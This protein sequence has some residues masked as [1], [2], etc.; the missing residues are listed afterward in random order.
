MVAKIATIHNNG[1][2]NCY[3]LLQLALSVDLLHQNIIKL[4]FLPSAK[5]V[6]KET[7]EGLGQSIQL[8]CSRFNFQFQFITMSLHKRH[9][10]ALGFT[11]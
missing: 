11:I 8:I 5:S 9:E 4:R 6:S 2:K 3:H 7:V 10:A 1:S